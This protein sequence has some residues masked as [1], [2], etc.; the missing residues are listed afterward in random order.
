MSRGHHNLNSFMITQAVHS[1]SRLVLRLIPALLA[2]AV[3]AAMAVRAASVPWHEQFDS[4]T[5]PEWQT[6]TDPGNTIQVQDGAL[7]VF[8]RPGSRA[9]IQ[10]V[11]EVNTF[12]AECQFKYGT[13]A[14]AVGL[15]LVWDSASYLRIGLNDQNRWAIREVLGTY[16]HD[17]DLGPADA[18]RGCSFAIEVAEDCIRYFQSADGQNFTGCRIAPRP[19][20]YASRPK[21]LVIGQESGMEVFPPPNPWVY[22]KAELKPGVC[23]VHQASVRELDGS[24]M[25]A[26]GVEREVLRRAGRD[27]LGEQELAA[28]GDPSFESVCRHYPALKWPRESIGVRGNRYAAGIA[29]DGSLQFAPDIAN[30]KKPAAFFRID[31]YRFGSNGCAKVLLHDWM[32]IVVARD[33]H[34]GLSFEETSFGYSE[35]FSAEAALKVYSQ[36]TV[37]NNGAETR[38]ISVSFEAE[39][40]NTVISQWALEV[41]AASEKRVNVQVAC[42]QARF[43]TNKLSDVGKLA[44][45]TRLVGKP[46]GDF[47]ERLR[48]TTNYWNQLVGEAMP[49]EIPETRVQ[50]AMRAW[51]SYSFLNVSKRGDT[52]HV[53]DGSGFY[54]QI[55]GYSAALYCHQLDLFGYHDFAAACLESLLS[56]TQTNGL[57]AVNFGSTDTGAALWAV[58]E[59]Y[60]ITRDEEWLRRVMPRVIQMCGWIESQ[61][62]A[63]LG[64]T[65]ESKLTRGL[66]RYRPYADLLHPAADYF[67]NGYLQKGMA[68]AAQLMAELGMREEAGRLKTSSEAYRKDILLS[69]KRSIFVDHGMRILPA[70]P[71]TRE[72][73]KEANGSANGYYGIIAPCMLEAGLPDSNDPKSGLVVRALEQRGGLTLGVSRFHNMVDHAY[74]YGYWMNRLDHEQVKKAI[75]GLYASM[76]VGMS[77]ETFSAVECSRVSTGEN[78]W[79]L[80]HTYSNTQQLRLLRNLLVREKGEDLL[81]AQGV[82]RAWLQPGKQVAAK[83]APTSFGPVTYTIKANADGS[84]H[85]HLIPPTRSRL[86]SIRLHLRH[87]GQVKIRQVQSSP[88]AR[89]GFSGE[90]ISI[91][92]PTE[93]LDL[94]VRF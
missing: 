5:G 87:P 76:A 70:I 11:L 24:S 10:R 67:S 71:D 68:S 34:D 14:G 84:M 29:W 36:L 69:M 23:H 62:H 13:P 78:Y 16:P 94:T 59:H 3:I 65:N 60:W 28:Q 35:G 57:L 61:R 91:K 90:I 89:I 72:L 79:T 83:A 6:E 77:R 38:K 20:R 52:Y 33:H 56:F 85:V 30:F 55:Y 1:A 2:S 41:P 19:A 80:P 53:C 86:E 4:H 40:G 9:H 32:P 74:A 50:N 31:G 75:L 27:L 51:T 22:P 66:I 49:F 44:P 54:G 73:W 45:E 88:A 17:Y 15:A 63:C 43:T 18:T 64:P 26:S 12:R 93:P 58:A 47:L 46:S 21:L 92:R 39:P 82:P 7:K 37:R 81:L 25:Q 8:A 48:E 42:P